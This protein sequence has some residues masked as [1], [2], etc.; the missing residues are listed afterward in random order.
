MMLN[1]PTH[2]GPAIGSLLD[3]PAGARTGFSN[4]TLSVTRVDGSPCVLDIPT[5]RGSGGSLIVTE[6]QLSDRLTIR[7]HWVGRQSATGADDC[8]PSA[9]LLLSK[10]DA[11]ALLHAAGGYGPA[12]SQRSSL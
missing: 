6:R 5:I 8:G 12:M 4:P 10:R 11:T 1:G 2:G 9:D 3:F 7:L